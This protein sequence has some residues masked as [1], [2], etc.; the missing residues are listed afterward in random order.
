LIKVEAIT[1][2]FDGQVVLDRLSLDVALGEVFAILGV[3]GA[4]KTTLLKCLVGLYVPVEGTITI[5]GLDRRADHLAIRRFTAWLA[6]QPLVYTRFT[7][8]QWLEL[9]ADIYDIPV[10]KRDAQVAELLAL[11]DL[12]A[13]ADRTVAHYSNG[14]YKKLA[15]AATLVTNARLYLMDEPFT[16]E[17]D[18]PGL[19]AFKEVVR[20]LG[21]R[22]DRTVVFSTQVVDIAEKVATRIG[23]LHG[24]DSWTP[25]RRRTCARATG[26]A[27]SRRS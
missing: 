5:D 11:F 13:M 17:V 1:K 9:V 24:G 6:D 3:N 7:G 18:P 27:A 26:R 15:L 4:G 22:G 2:R 21:R 16:G 20:G 10:E 12:D 14:Q 8:R 23:I 19:A 25:E